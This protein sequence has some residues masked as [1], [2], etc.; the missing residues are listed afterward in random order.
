MQISLIHTNHSQNRIPY[1]RVCT[2]GLFSLA[3]RHQYRRLFY[4]TNTVAAL[5]DLTS[6]LRDP[7]F[8]RYLP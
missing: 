6:S 1:L 7:H 4:E 5:F 2:H 3:N 8:P